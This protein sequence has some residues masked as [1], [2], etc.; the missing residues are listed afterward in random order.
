MVSKSNFEPAAAA[1]KPTEAKEPAGGL[2]GLQYGSSSDGDDSA[3][4][5]SSDGESSDSDSG[6]P[7]VSFF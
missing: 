6:K 2:L 1:T 5:Y 3:G 4:S 7:P